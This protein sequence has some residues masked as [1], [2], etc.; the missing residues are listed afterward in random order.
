MLRVARVDEKVLGKDAVDS[1]N[2]EL[3]H[4]NSG[5]GSATLSSAEAYGVRVKLVNTNPANGIMI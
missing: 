3:R 2:I 1:I 4:P 5:G